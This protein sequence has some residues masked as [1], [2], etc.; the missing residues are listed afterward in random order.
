[1]TGTVDFSTYVTGLAGVA[2]A[3]VERDYGMAPPMQLSTADLPA[4]FLRLPVGGRSRFT[5]AVEGADR[6]GTGMMTCE[7]VIAMEPIEQNQPEPNF[8]S[9][10][11]MV[12]A[13]TKAF[14]KA[15][16]ALSWPEA[17]SVQVRA[18]VIVAGIAYWAV[19]AS[20]QARG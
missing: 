15:D 5:L 2:V 8:V 19:V 12:D 9:T 13:V 3:D 14:V 20:I 18:D 4:K 10:T 11:A 7:V 6:H 17:V 16:V 1:M